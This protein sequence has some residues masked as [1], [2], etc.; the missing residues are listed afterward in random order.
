MKDKLRRHLTFSPDITVD[1]TSGLPTGFSGIAYSGGVVPNYGW[2]GDSAIDIGS[3]SIPDQMFALVNHDPD[4]RAGHC[5]VWI[6]GSAI[7]VAGQFSRMTAAGQSVA[8]EFMEKA[9]WKLSVG[10]NANSEEMSPPQTVN[11][12]GQSLTLSTIFRNAR[13]LE[14]SFVP[15]DADPNTMVAAFAAPDTP[16][17]TPLQETKSMADDTRMADLE[18]QVADLTVQLSAEKTRADTA[19][20]ALST[21]RTENRMAA[22][23][24]LFSE[25]GLEFSDEKAKPYLD[26]SDLSF[27]A[28]SDALKT[29]TPARGADP[30][31]FKATVPN[32]QQST[33]DQVVQLSSVDI[34][35]NRRKAMGQR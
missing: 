22:V 18:R 21:Y 17:P 5:R 10:F 30:A 19:E 12:N 9:P 7:H 28:V 4:Q 15:A 35:A 16:S 1:E 25:C 11:I 24:V 31:L 14:V 3:L 20:T 2:Y 8:G 27:S 26:M 33:G 6:D 32:G 13:I 29:K 23:K 34:Y